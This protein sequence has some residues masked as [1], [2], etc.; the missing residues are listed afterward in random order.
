ML[1]SLELGKQ[2]L[3]VFKKTKNQVFYFGGWTNI[4]GD[5]ATGKTAMLTMIRQYEGNDLIYNGEYKLDQGGSI[6]YKLSF[7]K[8]TRVIVYDPSEI[9]DKYN[10]N[11]NFLY[12]VMDP[13]W[14]ADLCYSNY[15]QLEIESMYFSYFF[16]KHK[17]TLQDNS[18]DTI[19]LFDEPERSASLL[20]QQFIFK[21][22]KTYADQPHIQVIMATHS[23]IAMTMSYCVE[24]CPKYKSKLAKLV[25]KIA[26]DLDN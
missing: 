9:T 19:I 20:S 7:D 18:V 24:L 5:N 22:I 12:G 16:K 23:I 17:Q 3:M 4:I 21:S 1:I 25:S 6:K 2:R 13:Q 26:K 14:I 11:N 10:R 15:S 8:P